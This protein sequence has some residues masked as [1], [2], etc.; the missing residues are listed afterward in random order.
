[1]DPK[2]KHWIAFGVAAVVFVRAAQN[3][4]VKGRV[5]SVWR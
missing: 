5:V 2:T 3:L 1:M 4:V